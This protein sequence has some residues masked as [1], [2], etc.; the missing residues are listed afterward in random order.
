M[1]KQDIAYFKTGL[2]PSE[3]ALIDAVRQ[4]GRRTIQVTTC[5]TGIKNIHVEETFSCDGHNAS[6]NVTVNRLLSEADNQDLVIK[7]RNGRVVSLFRKLL[8]RF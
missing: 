8:F 2:S 7:R 6:V 5:E 1:T 4:T 3:C